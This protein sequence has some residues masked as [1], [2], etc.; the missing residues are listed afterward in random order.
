MQSIERYKFVNCNLQ[1]RRFL[2]N[3]RLFNDRLF[4][5]I[6]LSLGI[7]FCLAPPSVS[8]IIQDGGISDYSS[9]A[10]DIHRSPSKIRLL[11]RLCQLSNFYFRTIPLLLETTTLD[12]N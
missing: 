3:E 2:R 1:S 11:C 6:V 5:L 10:Q 8:F 4:K 9:L 12:A 7:I